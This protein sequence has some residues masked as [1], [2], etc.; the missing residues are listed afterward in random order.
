MQYV[1]AE[2]PLI[3]GLTYY[4]RGLFP[5]GYRI[6]ANYAKGLNTLLAHQKWHQE[7]E[8]ERSAYFL[9]GTVCLRAGAFGVNLL[10]MGYV[11]LI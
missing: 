9:L 11:Q 4:N 6:Q 7:A 8:I 3:S 2:N 5:K 1:N 10:I